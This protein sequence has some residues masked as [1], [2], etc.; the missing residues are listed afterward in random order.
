MFI[1]DAFCEALSLSLTHTWSPL[2]YLNAFQ[3]L[4]LLLSAFFHLCFGQRL[5]N[6]KRLLLLSATATK[7][8]ELSGTVTTTEI[9]N[10]WRL[11]RS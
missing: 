4:L 6:T 9:E 3:T 5:L 8:P 11:S 1:E 2:V 10:S 7:N